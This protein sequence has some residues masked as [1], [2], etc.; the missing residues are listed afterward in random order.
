[1]NDDWLQTEYNSSENT[2]EQN[3]Q[4]GYLYYIVYHNPLYNMQFY[5]YTMIYYYVVG[6]VT[7][8][9]FLGVRI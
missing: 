9:G 7:S 2:F 8:C 6:V 1:M 3:Q 5:Y 4:P